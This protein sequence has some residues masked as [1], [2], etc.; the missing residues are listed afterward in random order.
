MPPEIGSRNKNFGAF[1]CDYPLPDRM[2]QF[3]DAITKLFSRMMEIKDSITCEKKGTVEKM[4]TVETGSACN[5][6]K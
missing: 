6:I 5:K 3:K 1:R 4:G 2:K